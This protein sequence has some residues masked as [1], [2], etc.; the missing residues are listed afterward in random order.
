MWAFG[1]DAMQTGLMITSCIDMQAA[2]NVIVELALR[3]LQS[4]AKP[5]HHDL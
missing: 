2:T 5:A 1:V 3:C 4:L